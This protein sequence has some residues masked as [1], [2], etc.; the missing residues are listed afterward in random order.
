MTPL[1]YAL[2]L[3]KMRDR[4]IGEIRNKMQLKKIEPEK[5]EEVIKF[6]IE[7]D[8]LDDERFAKNYVRIQLGTGQIGKYKLK[9]KLQRLFVPKEIIDEVIGEIALGAEQEAAE[10]LAQKWLV[11]KKDVLPE[12]RY[13]KLGRFLLARGFEIDVVKK[14]LSEVL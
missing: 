2:Y 10:V 4:S 11:K 13:E 9:F 8:F 5:I 3:L 7:K 12:K 1:E 14:I 6:L